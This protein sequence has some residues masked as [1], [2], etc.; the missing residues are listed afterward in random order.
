MAKRQAKTS[1]DK[2]KTQAKA[3]SLKRPRLQKVGF[4]ARPRPR[5]RP[6]LNNTAE[7]SSSL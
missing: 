5:P 7:V 4:K 1:A 6:R 3:S 2:A